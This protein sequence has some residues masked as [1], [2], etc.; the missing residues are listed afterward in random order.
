MKCPKCKK[1]CDEVIVE[2]EFTTTITGSK[3]DLGHIDLDIEAGYVMLSEWLD[4]ML[5]A[6]GKP[7]VLGCDNC[8]K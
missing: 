4:N 3:D 8:I 2:Q 6:K 1:E 7:V 5:S